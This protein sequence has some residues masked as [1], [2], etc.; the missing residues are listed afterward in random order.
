[1]SRTLRRGLA[2][3][4]GAAIMFT[5]ASTVGAAHAHAHPGPESGPGVCSPLPTVC[6]GGDH[7]GFGAL[8]ALAG[9]LLGGIVR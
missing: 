1:M 7:V 2:V 5:G 8:G 4:L 9:G 6:T 3:A